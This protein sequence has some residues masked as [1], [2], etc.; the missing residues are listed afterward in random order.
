[1]S[2]HVVQFTK[3][4]DFITDLAAGETNGIYHELIEQ[5]TA[6]NQHGYSRWLLTTIV[7]AIVTNGSQTHVAAL[8]IP[9]GPQVEHLNGGAIFA[10]PG[11]RETE[12]ARWQAARERHETIIDDLAR[13]LHI[14][15]V[16]MELI[17]GGIVNVPADLPFVLASVPLDEDT[18][19][20]GE[21]VYSPGGD[22]SPG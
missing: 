7:R 4:L 10:P 6:S 15:G 21:V 18:T 8:T 20:A 11:A 9:H 3:W 2:T 22:G 13:L 1:M 5:R 17:R 14:A 12:E 16:P 19:R